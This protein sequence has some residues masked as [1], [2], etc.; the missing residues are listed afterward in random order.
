[1]TYVVAHD[2]Y[3][4]WPT[5][6]R[7]IKIDGVPIAPRGKESMELENVTVDYPKPSSYTFATTSRTINPVFHLVELFYF[8]NG[9]SDALLSNYVGKM[10]EFINEATGRFD[11]S[12]GPAIYESLPYVISQLSAD[13]DSRRAIVP[14]LGRHHLVESS[15]DIPCN[16]LLGF[17]IR[18]GCLNMN[19]VTRSQDL[20]RGFI[21]DTL[22]FQLLQLMLA[23]LFKIKVGSY[24]HNIFSLHLYVTDYGKANTVPL[25]SIPEFAMKA[26]VPPNFN[27]SQDFW[28][29]ARKVC[30]IIEFSEYSAGP[31]DDIIHAIY[32]WKNRIISTELGVYSAWV[33]WWLENAK[34]K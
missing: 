11:G 26:P 27:T 23:N 2:L 30:A 33:N 1:M 4:A 10:D 21:Y 13:N 6:I 18:N 25:K 12:Y 22:E 20:Y 34:K 14:I 17:R 32:C 7:A 28:R 15:K 3:E 19:V 31:E 16:I 5:L 8:L 24:R 29:Y 9:R